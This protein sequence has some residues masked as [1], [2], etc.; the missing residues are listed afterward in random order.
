M[1][2]SVNFPGQG[3]QSVG[4]L[5]VWKQHPA[6]AA[7]LDEAN[8]VLGAD[9]A[10]VCHDEAALARTETTQQAVFTADVAAFCVLQAEGLEPL[11]VAGHSLGEFAALVASGACDFAPLLDV[12]RERSLA[13]AAAGDARPGTMLALVG[14]SPEQAAEVCDEARGDDILVVANINSQMQTV[15]AGE[16]AAIERA[17]AL[18]RERKAK[19]IRPNVA[20]AFHS[21]LM[22]P[23]KERID[24]ALDAVTIRVP[25]IPIVQNVTAQETTDPAIIEANLRVH[26]VSSVQ[27][28][29]STA[30]MVELGAE[31]VLEAGPGDVLTRLAKRDLKGVTALAVRSPQEAHDAM[32]SIGG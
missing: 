14:M 25:E 29:A 22:A 7:V 9:L 21:P 17:E 1:K 18:A 4:M 27:W 6:S 3:S 10:A 19:P 16:P 26:V 13:M 2:V 31:A 12:V 15:L 5:D 28:V 11:T 8:A 23:A 20:G 32:A 30:R 24:A